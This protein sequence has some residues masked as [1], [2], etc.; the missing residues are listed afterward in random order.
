MQ[1][2]ELIK[3][4]RPADAKLGTIPG[5]KAEREFHINREPSEKVRQRLAELDRQLQQAEPMEIIGMRETDSEKYNPYGGAVVDRSKRI[6][7]GAA[8]AGVGGDN[9]RS[10][11]RKAAQ[12][13]WQRP[14]EIPMDS[15]LDVDL[16][17]KLSGGFKPGDIE[18]TKRA[19]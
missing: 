13:M 3:R 7:T 6:E 9:L 18:R 2:A 15:A 8:P 4:E 14:S 19:A 17:P 11:A 16:D 12:E 10:G 1:K 5:T